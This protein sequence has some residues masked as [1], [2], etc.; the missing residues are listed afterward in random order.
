MTRKKG[1]CPSSMLPAPGNIISRISFLIIAARRN[2]LE[3]VCCFFISLFSFLINLVFSKQELHS[4]PDLH[5]RQ[6]ILPQYLHSKNL[7]TLLW[8][9]SLLWIMKRKINK[10]TETMIETRGDNPRN[11]VPQRLPASLQL[12]V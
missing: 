7:L 9:V 12:P 11:F 1:F 5:L 8:L 2:L 6:I 4:R 10:I 3:M